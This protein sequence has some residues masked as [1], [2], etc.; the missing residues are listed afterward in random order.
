[1]AS[2]SNWEEFFG[3]RKWR[4]AEEVSGTVIA[5]KGI[6]VVYAGGEFEI[7]GGGKFHSPLST[8]RGSKGFL[9][10]ELDG[11]GQDIGGSRIAVG[12]VVYRRARQAGAVSAL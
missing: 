5:R 2:G 3:S 9:L 11:Q 12:E 8:A 4:L 1:M 10:Q 7:T 6:S